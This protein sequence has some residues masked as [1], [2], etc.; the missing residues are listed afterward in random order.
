MF[1]FTAEL[2]FPALAQVIC[3]A[4]VIVPPFLAII[5][6]FA[7][8]FIQ[9]YGHTILRILT[10]LATVSAH[11]AQLAMVPASL[12]YIYYCFQGGVFTIQVNANIPDSVA[13]IYTVVL[14][15]AVALGFLGLMVAGLYLIEWAVTPVAVKG[16]MDLAMIEMAITWSCALFQRRPPYGDR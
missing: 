10:I 9:C 7:N 4:V 12:G 8:T 2:A 5:T 13:F 14:L 1:S 16:P 11:I 3:L 15:L 6:S